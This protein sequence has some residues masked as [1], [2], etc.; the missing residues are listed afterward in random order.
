M[1]SYL[2]DMSLLE[3]LSIS[4]V[5]VFSPLIK[6]RLVHGSSEKALRGHV[7]AMPIDSAQIL[8]QEITSLPRTD[9]S[10]NVGVTFNGKK[11]LW[12]SV[13]RIARNYAPLSINFLNVFMWLVYLKSIG[14]PYYVDIAIPSTEEE[15][16]SS[17]NFT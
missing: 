8:A 13:T 14:N 10:T 15:K 12:K 11:N 16:K 5:F 6:L 17:K 9:L 3:Q 2:P 1:P 4:K 7:I